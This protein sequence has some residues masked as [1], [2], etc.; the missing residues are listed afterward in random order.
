MSFNSVSVENKPKQNN[1]CITVFYQKANSIP[2]FLVREV[3]T[4]TEIEE[5]LKE[6]CGGEPLRPFKVLNVFFYF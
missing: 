5:H 6:V 2:T 1:I 4:L 3:E